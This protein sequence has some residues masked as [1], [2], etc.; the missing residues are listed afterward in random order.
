MYGM[1]DVQMRKKL[2]ENVNKCGSCVRRETG[3]ALLF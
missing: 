1:K 2:F 3:V